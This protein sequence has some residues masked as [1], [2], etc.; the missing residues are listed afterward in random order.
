MKKLLIMGGSYFIGK[1]VVNACKDTFETYVLNRGNKP[2]KYS[3]VIE[4]KADRNILDEMK[5]ALN[6]IDFDFIVDVSGLNKAHEEILVQSINL[7]KLKKFIFISS[8]AVYNIEVLKAPFKE[9]EELG[10]KSPFADYARNKIE[11]ESYLTQTIDPK[12]LFMLRPPVVYGEENYV[13]R[14][15]LI[16]KMIE[17]DMNIYIPKTNNQIQFVYANDLALQIKDALL[18]KINPGI[19]NVGTLKAPHF[20]E[21]VHLCERVLGKKANIIFVDTKKVQIEAR[22][23]FPFFDYDNILDV[24]KIRNY[25]DI[26]TPMEL[27]LQNAYRDYKENRDFVIIPEKMMH[28]FDELNVI[29]SNSTKKETI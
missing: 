25:S 13:L 20:D 11:A 28:I 16:F 22:Q 4:L 26:E 9:D 6:G 19:Y 24:T 10:G 27:G 7:K 23:F 1:R 3:N 15:R 17:E 21:W 14:E 18:G 29:F 12:S 5:Q 2:L 8:S